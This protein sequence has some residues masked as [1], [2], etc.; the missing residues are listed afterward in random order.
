MNLLRWR[1]AAK[2]TA[3]WAAKASPLLGEHL[4]CIW[5]DILIYCPVWFLQIAAW[6]EKE[7]RIAVSKL[8][9]NQFRG[10]RIHFSGTGA[11]LCDQALQCW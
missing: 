5:E 3:S 11:S 9:L 10:G 7:S 6:L 8:I 1:E 4:D 2:E